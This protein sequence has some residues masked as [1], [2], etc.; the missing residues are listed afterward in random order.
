MKKQ[1]ELA[2]EKAKQEEKAKPAADQVYFV[3]R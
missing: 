1:Q 3:R 2:E